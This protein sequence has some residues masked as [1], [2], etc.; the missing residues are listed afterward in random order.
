MKVYGFVEPARRQAAVPLMLATLD[1]NNPRQDWKPW[2]TAYDDILAE[3]EV[4]PSVVP[5][6]HAHDECFEFRVD[7]DAPEALFMDGRTWT[8]YVGAIVDPSK[9]DVLQRHRQYL[10]LVARAEHARFKRVGYYV[11]AIIEEA[12]PRQHQA[13]VAAELLTQTRDR[14]HTDPYFQW[15]AQRR[16][17]PLQLQSATLTALSR[18][19][20]TQE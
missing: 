20:R 1:G 19:I 8:D 17:L 16:A 3:S 12:G 10:A 5:A 7:G 4:G 2:A 6:E 14:L 13:D 11:F 15:V 9:P 18:Y